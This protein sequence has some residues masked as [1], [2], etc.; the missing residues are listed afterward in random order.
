[1]RCVRLTSSHERISSDR[2]CGRLV[3][4]CSGMSLRSCLTRR[5]EL[6]FIFDLSSRSEHTRQSHH[7][8]GIAALLLSTTKPTKFEAIGSIHKKP[9]GRQRSRKSCASFLDSYQVEAIRLRTCS[10]AAIE[11]LICPPPSRATDKTMTCFVSYDVPGDKTV[12]TLV[13]AS[14][15]IF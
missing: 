10:P 9:R 5:V 4:G 15:A 11:T 7:R 1:M 8:Q 3:G 12:K 13:G 6:A 2:G 14:A